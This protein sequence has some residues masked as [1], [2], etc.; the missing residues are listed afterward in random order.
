METKEQQEQKSEYNILYL[1]GVFFG[2]LLLVLAG[3]VVSLNDYMCSDGVTIDT[4]WNFP[5]GDY[6]YIK[7]DYNLT[8]EETQEWIRDARLK[9]GIS[10]EMVF[11]KTRHWCPVI[12]G[13]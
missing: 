11:E 1:A 2:S 4:F 6:A 13:G 5:C 9:K 3:L 10:T 7:C 8:L 12:K